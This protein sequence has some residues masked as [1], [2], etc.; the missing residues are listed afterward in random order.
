MY[1]IRSIGPAAHLT[2]ISIVMTTRPD[3]Y[4]RRSEHTTGLCSY[5]V[6]VRVYHLIPYIIVYTHSRQTGSCGANSRAL[7]LSR[8]SRQLTG[9]NPGEMTRLIKQIGQNIIGSV[10]RVCPPQTLRNPRVCALH[11]HSPPPSLSD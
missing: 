4:M 11:N 9:I 8:T 3:K 1:Y 10:A 2:R 7:C 5:Y 6:R